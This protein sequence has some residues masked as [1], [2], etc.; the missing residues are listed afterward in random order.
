LS[1]RSNILR[2]GAIGALI[3]LLM[4]SGIASFARAAVPA[5]LV[6]RK[7]PPFTR[8]AFD[9]STISISALRGKVVL[10]N[11]W[12]TWCAP[13]QAEMPVFSKWQ[14]QYGAQGLQVIGIS[15]DDNGARARR[16][17]L[18][19][20]IDYPMALGDAAL[21]RTYGGVL[22]LPVTY[23]I[24]RTGTIRAEF[25]SGNNLAGIEAEIKKLLRHS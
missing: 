18:K 2:H 20:A 7:A 25:Q 19:L 16:L 14:K 23:L 3:L 11:F 10:L 21:G 24:D 15:M 9:G 17:A 13:C 8:P 1:V 22:G 4:C 6:D 5:S 12:A